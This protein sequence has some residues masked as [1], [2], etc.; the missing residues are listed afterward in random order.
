MIFVF[1]DFKL[2]KILIKSIHLG[3]E[4]IKTKE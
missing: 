4:E 3:L 2:N 1:C